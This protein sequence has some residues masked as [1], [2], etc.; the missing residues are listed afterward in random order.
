MPEGPPL[1][2]PAVPQTDDDLLEAAIRLA[3]A[4]RR[5]LDTAPLQ[6]GDRV[7]LF[8]LDEKR[9]NGLTGVLLRPVAP[10]KGMAPRWYVELP[11]KSPLRLPTANLARLPPPL[12]ETPTP[13]A[14]TA[15]ICSVCAYPYDDEADVHHP[16]TNTVD[17]VCTL[18][19]DV[20]CRIM[21]TRTGTTVRRMFG[22]ARSPHL[23]R[24]ILLHL[25]PRRLSVQ[26]RRPY[27][28]LP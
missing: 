4:E 6:P 19:H 8:D 2:L 18:C 14:S 12:V 27:P 11:G 17:T 13:R 21:R 3:D 26:L 10:R 7:G 5:S 20:T 9:L 1:E 24:H 23:R 16:G 28:P 25:L 22:D 15:F